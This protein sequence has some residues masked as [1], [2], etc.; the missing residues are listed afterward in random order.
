M[1]ETSKLISASHLSTTELITSW[2][3]EWIVLLLLL[4]HLWS[5]TSKVLAHHRHELLVLALSLLTTKRLGIESGLLLRI[6][7]L[8]HSTHTI[9]VGLRNAGAHLDVVEG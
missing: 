6:E 8:L 4:L 9:V 3:T 2:S 7:W 1:L 5:L